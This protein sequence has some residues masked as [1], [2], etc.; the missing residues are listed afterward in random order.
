MPFELPL[1]CPNTADGINWSPPAQQHTAAQRNITTLKGLNSSFMQKSNSSFASCVSNDLM[2][3]VL[4]PTVRCQHY[5]TLLDT[6]RTRADRSSSEL[7]VV[8]WPST[9]R[10]T[11]TM[12]PTGQ[13]HFISLSTTKLEVVQPCHLSPNQFNCSLYKLPVIQFNTV[14]LQ[15]S[16]ANHSTVYHALCCHVCVCMRVKAATGTSH[17]NGTQ[18]IKENYA[19]NSDNITVLE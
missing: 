17:W 7:S 19:M 2:G 1:L 15:S 8:F 5:S 9:P 16:P 14:L 4:C 3:I 11:L 6:C 13:P 12:W 10:T 18:T